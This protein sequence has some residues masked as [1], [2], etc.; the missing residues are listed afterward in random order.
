[1]FPTS[2]TQDAKNNAGPSQHLRNTPPL[3]VAVKL[4]TPDTRGFTNKGSLEMLAKTCVDYGEFSAMA[5]RANTGRKQTVWRTPDTG[6]GGAPGLLKMGQTKRANGQPVRVR[7]ADQIGGQ[8][9]PSWVEWLMGW[10]IGWTALNAS[11]TD[12]SPLPPPRR[13]SCFTG[14]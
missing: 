1:M 9:N 6:A 7:L 11:A 2:A 10:P 12:K 4:P 5:Y 14:G 13:S 8:L 3:N